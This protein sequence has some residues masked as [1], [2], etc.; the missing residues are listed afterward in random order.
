MPTFRKKAGP[1]FEAMVFD[2]SHESAKAI[3]AW[4]GDVYDAQGA[5]W[6]TNQ[7]MTLPSAAD[8]HQTYSAGDLAVKRP[9]GVYRVDR[10]TIAQ[11]YEAVA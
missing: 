6:S 2:G 9:G 10:Y 1:E 8:D 5:Y 11:D 3:F 4:L 7:T